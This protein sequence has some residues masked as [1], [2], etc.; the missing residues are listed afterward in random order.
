MDTQ[1]N[2]LSPATWKG[3]ARVSGIDQKTY[4]DAYRALKAAGRVS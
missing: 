3:A 1:P 2:T 4:A